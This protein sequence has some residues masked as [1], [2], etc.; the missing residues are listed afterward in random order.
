MP[1]GRPKGSKGKCSNCDEPGHNKAT[2]EKPKRLRRYDRTN[3]Y[4]CSFCCDVLGKK[5]NRE[6]TRHN[7]RTCPHRELMGSL[8]KIEIW[9]KQRGKKILG[10]TLIYPST[11]RLW[12]SK[13]KKSGSFRA[14]GTEHLRKFRENRDKENPK[15][16]E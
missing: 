14:A 6:W 8:E 11:E 10:K 15:G 4:N 5:R 3:E 16:G 7:I 2:C 13:E 9:R 12:E 1:R